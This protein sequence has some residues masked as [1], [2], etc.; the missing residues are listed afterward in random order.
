MKLI[1]IENKLYKISNKDYVIFEKM[2]KDARY[3]DA[4]NNSENFYKA[5]EYIEEKYKPKAILNGSYN[6]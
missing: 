3:N 1:T 2:I 4:H 6:Y 5:L